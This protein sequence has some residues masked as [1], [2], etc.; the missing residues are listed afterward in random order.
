MR[1]AVGDGKRQEAKMADE[2]ADAVKAAATAGDVAAL[3]QLV[4]AHG[5]PAVRLDTNPEELTAL[6]W[7]AASGVVEAVNY[8]LASPVLADPRACRS[9]NFTPLH[10]AAMQGHAKVCEVLLRAG[11]G[12]DVQTS[13]QG[14]APLHSA[15]FA[16]HVDAIRVL[17]AHG[18]DRELVNYR[19]ERPADTARRTGQAEAV[20]VLEAKDGEPDPPEARLPE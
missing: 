9:N 8:L 2:L 15:A 16:G 14:Y 5:G 13:P 3:R 19:G 20:R 18:A 7:A 1:V 6:H 10:A 4:A 17:L 12:V 11:A